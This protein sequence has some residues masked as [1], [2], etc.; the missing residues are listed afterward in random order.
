MGKGKGK[1]MHRL[2]KFQSKGHMLRHLAEL[3]SY[4]IKFCF[5]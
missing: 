5:G 2:P 1:K 3:S 4:L